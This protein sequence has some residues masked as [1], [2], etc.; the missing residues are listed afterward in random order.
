[1]LFTGNKLHSAE[2]LCFS[3]RKVTLTGYLTL[4]LKMHSLSYLTEYCFFLSDMLLS[5]K[6]G[7]LFSNV[8]QKA[9]YH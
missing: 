5:F 7:L 8:P 6:R 9:H 4:F 1:M 3:S 2:E